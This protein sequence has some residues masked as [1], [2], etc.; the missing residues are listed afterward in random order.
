MKKILFLIITTGVVFFSCKKNDKAL[1]VITSVRSIDT[2]TRDS[3]FTKAMP[4]NLI[5]IQGSNLSGLQAVYFND[6]S[7]YF[8]PSYAT[9]TNIIITIPPTAQTAATRPDV[10]SVIRIV[11]DH[12]ET[13]YSFQLYLFPPQIT[14]LSF[15][16]SGTVVYINGYNFQGVNKITFPVSGND[17]ALSYTVNKTF[18]QIAA[19]IPAGTAFSDSLRVYATFGSGAFSYPPPMT[20]S[21]VSNENGVAGST[22]TLNGTNFVGISDVFFPGHIAGTNLQITSVSQLTVDVPTGVTMVDSL[23]LSGVLGTATSPQ[24]FDTYITHPSPGYLS[25]FDGNGAGDNTGFV[26]W[27]GGYADASTTSS[28]YPGG[29]GASGVLY[30]SSQIAGNSSATSQGNPGLLQLNAVPWVANT[31]MSINNYALK[32]EVYVRNTWSAGEIWISLGGWYNWKSYTARYAPWQLPANNG[33]YK[34]SGWVTETIPLNQFI[35]GNEFYQTAWNPGGAPV[36]KFSDFPT[37]EI[38]F[39]IANGSAKVVPVGSIDI[40]I[41]NV[42]IVK[43]Q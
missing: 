38:A 36:A 16:N 30:Q 33:K 21:S 40:A 7:A 2:T 13:T 25:T 28:N 42:R 34:P 20:I 15:D 27:T 26:G 43:T 3:L 31:N 24:L 19:E 6:T 4:G 39:L 9:N 12:G 37:T 18:T 32:F 5:V 1:P 8:N 14:S 29:T 35:T 22:I 41:D 11:T 17:T 23:R 10:P